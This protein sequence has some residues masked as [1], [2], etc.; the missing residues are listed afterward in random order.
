MQTDITDTDY[1]IHGDAK[2]QRYS[3]TRDVSFRLPYVYT[4][5]KFVYQQ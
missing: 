2:K 3:I 5:H 1:I 4:E